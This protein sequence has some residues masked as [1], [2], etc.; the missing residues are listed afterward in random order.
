MALKRVSQTIDTSL[1]IVDS[2]IFTGGDSVVTSIEIVHKTLGTINEALATTIVE[3]V[4]ER[5]HKT[6]EL[7]DS[8]KTKERQAMFDNAIK[9]YIRN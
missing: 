1:N 7:H 9:R 6:N 8:F 3:S 5:L 4:G 2:L